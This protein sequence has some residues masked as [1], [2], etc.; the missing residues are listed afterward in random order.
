MMVTAVPAM[1]IVARV[2]SASVRSA[3]VARVHRHPAHVLVL[4]V[5]Q[6]K[7]VVQVLLAVAMDGAAFVFPFLVIDSV[8][9]KYVR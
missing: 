5:L 7:V 1:K 6:T 4:D 9:V 8:T 3:C 2:L